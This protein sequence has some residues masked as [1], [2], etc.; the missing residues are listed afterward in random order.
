MAQDIQGDDPIRPHKRPEDFAG[1][2][3]DT[4]PAVGIFWFAVDA[5]GILGMLAQICLLADAEPY[6]DC[7]TFPDGHY[8]IWTRWRRIGPPD[9]ALARTVE[10]TEYDEWPRGRIVFDRAI[11]RFIVYA[12]RRITSLG[13]TGRIVEY[14]R[15]PTD[16]VIIRHDQHYSS[17]RSIR[18]SA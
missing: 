2:P 17:P 3:E 12:D 8:E 13:L 4:E 14:F 15:L 1:R 18:A 10:E 7:L 5:A 6:G 11:D 9:R 16:R